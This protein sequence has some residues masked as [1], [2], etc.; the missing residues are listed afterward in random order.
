MEG[1]AWIPA[2]AKSGSTGEE[3]PSKLKTGD[4]IAKIS[5]SFFRF[6]ILCHLTSL[7]GMDSFACFLFLVLLF[8]KIFPGLKQKHSLILLHFLFLL[9]SNF[10]LSLLPQFSHQP[11]VFYSLGLGFFFFFTALKL[12]PQKS[13]LLPCPSPC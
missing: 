4:L 10:R 3:L 1:N 2:T 6:L 8:R 9:P 13:I 11:T 5:V 12:L 7:L